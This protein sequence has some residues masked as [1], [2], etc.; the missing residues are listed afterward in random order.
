LPKKRNT[1]PGREKKNKR[2][3]QQVPTE[4]GGK[5]Q[6]KERNYQSSGE[7]PLIFEPFEKGKKRESKQWLA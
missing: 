4:R 5:G 2:K 1:K 6:K 7:R 3:A